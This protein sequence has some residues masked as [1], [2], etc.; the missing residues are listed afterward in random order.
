MEPDRAAA[1]K[2]PD[3]LLAGLV[4]LDLAVRL[5]AALRPLRFLDG[6]TIPDDAYLSL[7]IARSLAR[8]LGPWIGNGPTSGFQPL[9]V[10]LA[11]PLQALFPHDPDAALR[12]ALL[13]LLAA[14]VAALVLLYRFLRSVLRT[15]FAA[16]TA[17]LA[18]VLSPYALHTTLNG[19]E[20]TLAFATLVALFFAL[21]RAR[22]AGAAAAAGRAAAVGACLGLAAFARL[23]ALV[24]APVVAW[25]LARAAFA[26]GLG[27]AE[28]VRD[29]AIAGAATLAVY[30]P[31]LLWLHHAT[32]DWLPV[33]G[34]ALHAMGIANVNH[35]PGLRTIYLPMALR[36]LD[37]IARR[38]AFP[39]ALL[40]VLATALAWLRVP[41]AE[42]L[43]R[44]RPAGPSAC[45]GA[46]LVLAY[47]AWINAG[48]Y[49]PRYFF[50]LL[51]PLLLA[52]GGLLDA[53]AGRLAAAP[54]RRALAAALLLFVVAGNVAQ[55]P[56]TRTYLSRNDRTLGYANAGRWLRERFPAGTVIGG[57][58]SGAPAYYADSLVVVNLDGVVN[59][60]AHRALLDRRLLDYAR[61]AGVRY[62]FGMRGDPEY[63][64]AETAHPRP[65]DLVPLGRMGDFTTGPDPWFLWRVGAAPSPLD[66]PLP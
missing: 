21:D 35:E 42:W 15:R 24:A 57:L 56:F 38:N 14:D 25:V 5:P 8:G 45:F 27:A 13:L 29:V 23:D 3:L 55:P 20:T 31:W 16:G 61:E 46:A 37:T 6:L 1:A 30:A 48:W 43:D 12:A 60:D 10:V 2:R 17:A 66:P 22:R 39:I 51:L 41:R 19:L 36:A 9:Y 58:Q 4:A 33:S 65:D 62:V 53:C 26:R 7:A 64:V 54:G 47:V 18:W 63:L 59:R 52:A 40:L 11:A 49:Y 28:A 50:P 34:A 44:L 32:G